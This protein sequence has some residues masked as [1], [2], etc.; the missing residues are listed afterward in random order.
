[1][2]SKNEKESIRMEQE[3]IC[4]GC[5]TSLKFVGLNHETKK[6]WQCANKKCGREGANIIKDKD[7]D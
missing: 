1:M 2:P 4:E 6:I 5:G 7:N 3:P